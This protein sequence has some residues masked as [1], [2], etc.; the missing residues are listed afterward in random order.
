M[1]CAVPPGASAAKPSIGCALG[2]HLGALTN[3]ESIQLPNVQAG[4]ADG[5]Y[6]VADLTAGLDT[7][8]VN[9]DGL[10]CFKAFPTNAST[11]SLLQ[12]FYNLLDNNASGPS[13]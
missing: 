12:C 4:L 6:D 9:D 13:G 5:I 1:Q 7:F 2:F 8:D 11:A 10:V 3:E